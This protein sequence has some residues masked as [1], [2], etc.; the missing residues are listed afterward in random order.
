MTS[1]SL[2][3]V[4]Y[5]LAFAWNPAISQSA[6]VTVLLIVAFIM[7]VL[8]DISNSETAKRQATR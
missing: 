4:G 1:S 6:T 2:L 3:S 5:F 7:S 8:L